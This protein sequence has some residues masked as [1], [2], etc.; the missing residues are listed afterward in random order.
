VAWR[1]EGGWSIG[2]TTDLDDPGSIWSSVDVSRFL[3]TRSS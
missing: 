2:H 3:P 1:T